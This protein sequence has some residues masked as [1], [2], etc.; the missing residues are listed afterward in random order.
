[1]KTP[2]W[3]AALLPVALVGPLSAADLTKVD[4]TIAKEPAYKSK[5]PR[6]CL[7]VFGPEA[8]TRVW[9]VLDGDTLYVDR[10]GNGDLTEKGE[11]V[12]MPPFEKKDKAGPLLLGW[13]QIEAGPITAAPKDLQELR[14]IQ[15]KINPAHKPISDEE[16]E[17]LLG[18]PPDG[19]ITEVLLP[20]HSAMAD[21]AGMLQFA[22]R[23]PD[24]P[25][26][27]F[28]GP[29]QISL[30]PMEKLVRGQETQLRVWVGT[31]GLENGT[32]AVR[33]YE[34]VPGDACPVADLEFA[35][36]EAGK[37]PIRRRVTL[38]ERC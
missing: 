37:E 4:R 24:A 6:Y 16:A 31:P 25:I 27:H 36:K 23:P 12:A 30:L 7:L 21:D 10:N 32:F 22:S 20:N 28:G 38:K 34:G 5:S 13:R 19:L 26:I 29:L 11:K 3:L 1:L 15:H 17:V 35:N 2:F 33:S 14:L 18:R 9:L 8:K